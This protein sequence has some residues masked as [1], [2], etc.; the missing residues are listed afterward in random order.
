VGSKVI[1]FGEWLPDQAD[2]LNAGVTV[3]TNVLPAANGYHSMNSF[4]P[5]SNAATATIKGIFAA[6]DN[7]SNTKLF[8]GD[9]TKL[10][11]HASVDNDLD[12]ISK[13]GGYTLTDFER[14]RFVQFGD[15]VI[16]AGGVGETPQKF[17]LGTSSAFA[18]LGGTPPKADFIAVVRDFVWLANVDTGSGRVPYQCYWSGFNDPTSWTA[19]VNQSDFQNLPDS[20]AI[21]GLVGGEYAT[22]LTER[23]I[24]RAT[25]TGPPLIWQFDK[26]VS[27]RGCAFKESVCNVGGLVFFLAN[28]GFYAFDGQRATPIG[29]EKVNE[30][31]KNDFDSN[32]DYRM[33]ASVDPINEVAMWSYTSTQSP[34][35]QPDKIIM[36]NYTLNKWSLAEVEADLLAPMFSSGYTVDG[37]D[38]LSATVDGLSIQLDSRFFKGGQYFFGGA[39][40]DKIYTFTGAPLTATIETSEVPVSMGK[41]SI[42]TRVYPYYED[43]TVSMAVG[44]R[45]TQESQHVFTS[46]VSPND[47]GFVPFRSQGRYHRARMTLSDGWSKA[48]GID[49]EAREIGRR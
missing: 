4:V 9:A 36:Y 34:S 11:L 30:F 27:E 29:S 10:Y 3:A 13:A 44:T 23:A 20:G 18:D 42:V 21:T 46:A 33:S 16:A 15:D 24:F 12:D 39:Y 1:P 19:G 7:A 31:F 35:G 40:G 26:V 25:Y 49:I 48:L 8:A 38:N 17:G 5:Y 2:L 32:Y 6:K 47:A 43:G 37:L 45:N 14:W 41:N 28:D 22:V